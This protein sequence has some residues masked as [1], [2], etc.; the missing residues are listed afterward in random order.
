MIV[1]AGLILSPA[2]LAQSRETGAI[3]GTVVD[4][5]K[6]PLPGVTVS[7]SGPN[8]MGV[9][10]A[11]TEA[12]G[13]YRFPALP[14][15]T[16]AVKA[17]LQGFKT[18]IREDIRLTTT[19]RLTVDITL[20]PSAV[21][22]QV[23]VIAQSPTV[24][25]KTSE[26]ASVT[27]TSEIL[28]NVPN[29]QFVSDLVNLAPGVNN[30]VAYGASSDTGISYQI[31]GVGVGDPE[32]GSAWV[33]LDYNVVEE[34]KVMGVGLNA[35]YG[36]FSGVIFNTIT[37]S[38]GNQLSG[39]A[40]FTFQDTRKGFWTAENNAAYI[41]E[42]SDLASPI[43]GMMDGS[44]HLGGPITKD[45]VWFF[46]GFQYYR[47]KVRPAGFD[48]N[49]FRD[50]KQPRGFG[51]I[52]TQFSSNFSLTAYV[53]I[54][55][56]KG[57]NRQASATHWNPDVCVSQKSPELLANVNFNYI[58]SPKTFLEFKS[59]FFTGYYYLTPQGE[60]TAVFSAE[61]YRWNNNNQW[62]YKA[63]RKRF[64]ATAAMTHYAEDFI[65]GN[66]DFKFG[67]EFEYGW[68]R[69]RYGYSGA[70]SWYIYDYYG[71][72]YAYQYV[73]YDVN[74]R[75]TRTEFFA[76]DA[77]AISKN[78]TLNFGARVSLMNG[79]AKYVSGSIYNNTRIA[80]RV[81]FAWDIFGDHSTVVKGHYGQFTDS[82][83]TAVCDRF[84]P[85]SAYN[86]RLQY[87]WIGEGP[88]TDDPADPDWSLDFTTPHE[89]IARGANLKHPYLEQFTVGIEREL[90]KDASFSVSYINRKWK[91]LLGLYDT[92][93]EYE[94]YPVTD[95]YTGATYTLYNQLNPGTFQRTLA[96]IKAGDPTGV[97]LTM[98]YDAFR[99]YQGVEFM[100]NKRMSNR[101]QLLLSYVLSKSTGT[102]DN[103]M[104][105]DIGWTG[106]AGL[107]TNDPN[108]WINVLGHSLAD[109]THMLKAQGTYILPFG[110]NLSA[111]FSLISGDTYTRQLRVGLDQ[112]RVTFLTESRGSRRYPTVKNLDFRVE[113]TFLIQKKYRIGLMMDVFNV[114]N[115][116]TINWWGTRVDYD[117]GVG[118]VWA[119]GAPAPGPDG[120]KVLGLVDPRAI[121]LGVRFFF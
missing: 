64:Q 48:P 9:R 118:G 20:S 1:L 106:N 29:W 77:W 28:R 53:E 90:F 42:F 58:L 10:T 38:G 120:H 83:Y 73:G 85:P 102:I 74:T 56:Y 52:Q 40:E 97:G 94:T 21:A 75:Y 63:D 119:D 81:G 65:K 60:G 98:P 103:D 47:S 72:Y 6:T 11:V 86:P 110:I 12:D 16:Y 3:V 105:G 62:W 30:N 44:F 2:L 49:S 76:Q 45:K 18:T 43:R 121:R 50:Y 24:D 70:N 100:F 88:W 55:S 107:D 113:K 95:P 93:A 25:V 7:V 31:D 4:D 23:T 67:A 61:E 109:P 96:N 115:D 41:E 87:T 22:E 69:S 99:K 101:W 39:H 26:T 89:Q 54:D 78:F 35:E 112:G 32:A 51:K 17:E 111:Y 116:N 37:K 14:P 84:N 46:G 36:A 80:P 68:A 8:L 92:G 57:I 104:A 71:Y 91:N 15:G 5:Q 19:L 66:H 114:F 82:M 34:F 33:F 108:Y 59:A 117:W 79:H 13:S 27:L